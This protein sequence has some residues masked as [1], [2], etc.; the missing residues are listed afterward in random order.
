M[1]QDIQIVRGA[2]S[3]VRITDITI[4]GATPDLTGWS[5]FA[6]VRENPS[7]NAP[8]LLDFAADFPTRIEIE[9]PATA[10]AVALTFTASMTRSLPVRRVAASV[11][12]QDPGDPEIVHQIA[13]FIVSVIDSTTVIP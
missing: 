12:I 10:P 5:V 9:S 7:S 8:I 11:K 6:Q 1:T 3:R 2:V 13:D 4:D